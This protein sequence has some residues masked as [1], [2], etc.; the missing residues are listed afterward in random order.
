MSNWSLVWVLGF[1]DHVGRIAEGGTVGPIR[2]GAYVL[3]LTGPWESAALCIA[4]RGRRALKKEG[5][6]AGWYGVRCFSHHW[7]A[8]APTLFIHALFPLSLFFKYSP[9]ARRL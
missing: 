3:V 1:R 5:S 6:H 9:S 4:Q 7:S 8:H 2:R